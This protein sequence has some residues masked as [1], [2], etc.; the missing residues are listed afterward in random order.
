MAALSSSADDRQSEG[1]DEKTCC[2]DGIFVALE[3]GS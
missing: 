1:Q 3:S 2:N